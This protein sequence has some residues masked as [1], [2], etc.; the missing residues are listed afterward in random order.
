MAFPHPYLPSSMVHSQLPLDLGTLRCHANPKGNFLPRTRQVCISSVTEVTGCLLW[1][2]G[3]TCL[4]TLWSP[5]RPSAAHQL[6]LGMAI[7]GGNSAARSG[8][9]QSSELER[10]DAQ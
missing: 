6:A 5:S 1:P 10:G 4:V 7:T 3:H 9:S 8:R 2:R